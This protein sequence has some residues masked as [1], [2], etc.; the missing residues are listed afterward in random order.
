V[1]RRQALVLGLRRGQAA[2]D[3]TLAQVAAA[4]GQR[5]GLGR[6]G[7]SLGPA[8][9]L[10]VNVT[11]MAIHADHALGQVDVLVRV[12]LF[13]PL[14]GCGV[15]EI[16]AFSG[17]LSDDVEEDLILMVERIWIVFHSWRYYLWVVKDLGDF[18]I[19]CV[20]NTYG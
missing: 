6:L 4:A 15:A 3:A 19:V 9:E 5:L 17:Y 18:I 10:V 2:G 14:A 13:R 16:A 11:A 8:H 20:R 1:N 12:A 7:V